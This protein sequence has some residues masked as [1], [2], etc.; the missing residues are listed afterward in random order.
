MA[1]PAKCGVRFFYDGTIEVN[2]KLY[3]PRSICA[4][5]GYSES[6]VHDLNSGMRIEGYHNLSCGHKC[7]GAYNEV[8]DYCS[9]CGAK[10]DKDKSFIVESKE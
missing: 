1:Y 6:Y 4:V 5:V 9:K 8:P 10:V 2:K 7:A 3:V